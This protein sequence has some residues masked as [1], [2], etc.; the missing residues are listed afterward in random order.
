MYNVLVHRVKC[1]FNNIQTQAG[2]HM[3]MEH[4]TIR[5]KLLYSRVT[6]QTSSNEMTERW[7]IMSNRGIVS[8]V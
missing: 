1:P 6:S 4:G 8:H 7:Q 2:L 3:S 5:H